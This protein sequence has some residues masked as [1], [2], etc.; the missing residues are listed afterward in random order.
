MSSVL[1][2][3]DSCSAGTGQT[4]PRQL[5]FEVQSP[6]SGLHTCFALQSGFG[7]L[8]T[9]QGLDTNPQATFGVALWSNLPVALPI[10]QL[11]VRF[12]PA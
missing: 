5:S 1:T 3:F 10:S 11:E 4:V 9:P 6:S 8:D 7:P 2:T 12:N